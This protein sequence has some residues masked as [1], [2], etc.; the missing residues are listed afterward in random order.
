MRLLK[1][2]AGS[3]GGSATQYSLKDSSTMVQNEKWRHYS[4]QTLKQQA[5]QRMLFITNYHQSIGIRP[6]KDGSFS[7]ELNRFVLAWKNLS[8]SLCT[9]YSPVD[10]PNCT[11]R[12]HTSM[13]TSLTSGKWDA[14]SRTLAAHLCTNRVPSNFSIYLSNYYLSHRAVLFGR[15]W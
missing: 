4:W 12:T 6:E 15:Y 11:Y 5:P 7:H 1:L 3:S 8:C 13:S 14:P 2:L 9:V 10:S